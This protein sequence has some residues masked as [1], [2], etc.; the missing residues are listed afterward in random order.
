MEGGAEGTGNVEVL[1]CVLG[2]RLLVCRLNL[3]RGIRTKGRCSFVSIVWTDRASSRKASAQRLIPSL[4]VAC[5]PASSFACE[6]ASML[7]AVRAREPTSAGVSLNGKFPI[8]RPSTGLS[9]SRFNTLRRHAPP[10]DRP[11]PEAGDSNV[12]LFPFCQKLHVLD[13]AS[14]RCWPRGFCVVGQNWL[15]ME[16]SGK[17]ARK[18]TGRLRVGE[19]QRRTDLRKECW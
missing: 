8:A 13:A 18:M 10:A 1:S 2:L 3:A 6:L 7:S 12:P 17:A 4:A 9:G 5:Q 14:N 11:G 15:A 19:V 16:P